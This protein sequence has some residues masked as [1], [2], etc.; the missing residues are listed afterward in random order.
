MPDIMDEIRRAAQANSPAYKAGRE[1][2]ARGEAAPSSPQ[3]KMTTCE[4]MEQSMFALGHE[5]YKKD[6]PN[7][8]D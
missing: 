8:T 7:A 4:F 1:S 5:D 2:A 6:Q 3:G